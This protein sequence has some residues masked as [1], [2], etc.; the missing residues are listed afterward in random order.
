MPRKYKFHPLSA[1][2]VLCLPTARRCSMY[3]IP[4]EREEVV[5][6]D[7]G[8]LEPCLLPTAARWD[9]HLPPVTCHL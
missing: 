7:L 9:N 6:A 8:H 2:G 5:R 1:L 4:P 3:S